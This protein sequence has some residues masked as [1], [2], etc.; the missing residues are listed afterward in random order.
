MGNHRRTFS[1]SGSRICG[2]TGGLSGFYNRRAAIRPRESKQRHVR[3]ACSLQHASTSARRSARS[4]DIV[5]QQNSFALQ[6][7]SLI[8]KPS[9][10]GEHTRD[11]AAPLSVRKSSL[12]LACP[13]AA[14]RLLYRRIPAPSDF[15]GKKLGLVEPPLPALTPVQRHRHDNVEMLLAR[16][17]LRK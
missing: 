13:A 12:R 17:H 7:L 5:H 15:L 3:R 6:G 1:L 11:I 2:G 16:Q 9:V 4:E 14:N 8:E 10:D